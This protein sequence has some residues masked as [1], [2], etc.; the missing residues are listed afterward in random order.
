VSKFVGRSV[1]VAFV[2][3][4]FVKG[5][6][7]LRPKDTTAALTAL[8]AALVHACS[9]GAPS[10]DD[11]A[12]IE[13]SRK[14]DL[15]GECQSHQRGEGDVDRPVFDDAQVLGVKPG[16]FGGSFLGQV[17]LFTNLPQ[18]KPEPSLGAF[19]GLLKTRAKPDL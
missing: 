16:E 2:L 5:A 11:R 1:L 7:V 8:I 10:A 3:Y 18:T 12:A 14:G 13:E 17:P 6:L 9:P 15:V 19:D 4:L